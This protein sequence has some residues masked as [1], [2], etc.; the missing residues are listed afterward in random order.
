MAAPGVA[1]RGPAGRDSLRPYRLTVAR[2]TRITP[3]M[4]RVTLTGPDLVHYTEVGP[5]PRCK[6]LLPPAPGAEVVVPDSVPFWDAL[7]ALPESLRPIVRTYTVRAARP[8]EQEIDI[9]F[10]LHGD[11][12]PASRWAASTK[13]GDAVG[14]YGCLSS[15]APPADT[16][17][18]LVVGDE[19]AL[20]A[21]TGIVAS[22]PAGVAARVI[23]EVD[24]ADEQQPLESAADLSVTWLHR[25]GAEPGTGTGLLD[26]VRAEPVD[27]RAYAWVAGESSAVQAIRALLVLE[28]DLTKQ[29]VYFSGYWRRGHAEDD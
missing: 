21:I 25:G 9:D 13:S 12:G 4:L 3:H 18:Y 24:S 1:R 26:A 28:R 17:A 27:Q 20:P 8:A 14:L 16:A 15:F 2:T 23:V 22:L 10:V 29:R 6:V 19:T 7:A 5:E 11:T